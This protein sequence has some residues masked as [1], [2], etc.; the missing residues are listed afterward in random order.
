MGGMEAVIFIGV[1]AT[2]K[3]TFYIE[4]FSHT[5][6]RINLDMLRTRQRED[7]LLEACIRAS[8][9]FVVDN[10][11]VLVREREKYIALAKPAGFRILGYFFHSSLQEALSRN[12]QRLGRAVIPDKG[13]IAKFRH[14][15][16]PTYAEG[17]DRL[18]DVSIDPV[19]RFTI[20]EWVE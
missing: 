14:L 12:R 2:G 15:Q 18:Y 1:Q 9:S 8:Q 10:T 13:V 16:P 5:H 7:L 17:F 4:H 20:H 11:N 6:V 3:S 19:Q